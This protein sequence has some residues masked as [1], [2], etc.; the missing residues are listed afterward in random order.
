MNTSRPQITRP[1]TWTE[2]GSA[3]V[4]PC[5]KAPD[6]HAAGKAAPAG[7]L[8]PVVGALQFIGVLG[9]HGIDRAA[10]AGGQGRCS[11]SG[12]TRPG[13]CRPEPAPARRPNHRPGAHHAAVD[14]VE[15][16][17][18]PRWHRAPRGWPHLACRHCARCG[19]SRSGLR[20][21]T[22]HGQIGRFIQQTARVCARISGMSPGRIRT[23]AS[24]SIAGRACWAACPVP[25]RSDWSPNRQLAP[26]QRLLRP[27]RRRR[28]PRREPG[29]V[30]VHRLRQADGSA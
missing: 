17:A 22:Q 14:F 26:G 24:G 11:R 10:R 3:R 6:G 5:S 18:R 27:G 21:E 19:H 25:R 16:R 1:R 15:W 28:R 23:R 20:H 12:N 2:S 13:H 8:G 29:P 9:D 30:T 7:Q 4:T